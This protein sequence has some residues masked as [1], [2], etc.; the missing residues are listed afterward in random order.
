MPSPSVLGWNK[1]DTGK[2]DVFWTYL[3]D[4]GAKKDVAGNVNVSMEIAENCDT[5]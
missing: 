4:V 3:P 2:W 5:K 1:I